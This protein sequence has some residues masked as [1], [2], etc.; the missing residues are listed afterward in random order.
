MIA[1]RAS[2]RAQSSEALGTRDAEHRQADEDR[3]REGSLR[4]AAG[5]G[6]A[7]PHAGLFAGSPAADP[8]AGSGPTPCPAAVQVR[9]PLPQAGRRVI[10]MARAA[11]ATR[12][13]SDQIAPRWALLP[14]VAASMRCSMSRPIRPIC[15]R[16]R[17]G[18]FSSAAARAM[19]AKPSC[20][21]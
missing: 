7:I 14:P 9:P 2:S 20:N 16:S 4:L 18:G 1:I 10:G 17:N 13:P 5:A 6:D 11:A 15:S 12:S 8:Q 21:A 19:A 3:V